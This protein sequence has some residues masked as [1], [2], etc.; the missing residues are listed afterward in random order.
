MVLPLS[1]FLQRGYP[2]ERIELITLYRQHVCASACE[3]F[4]RMC[5]DG[6]LRRLVF[7]GIYAAQYTAYEKRGR[8]ILKLSQVVG[9]GERTGRRYANQYD[10]T[11][12]RAVK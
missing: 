1:Q 3:L 4:L 5:S 12:R 6:E 10:R 7:I 9:I 11:R 2:A 8:L